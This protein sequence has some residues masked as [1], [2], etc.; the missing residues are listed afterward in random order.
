MTPTNALTAGKSHRWVGLLWAGAL[1]AIALIYAA[2]T[3]HI[4]EDFFIT[5]R[6]SRNLAEGFGLTVAE[7]MWKERP[8]VATRV[9]G[10]DSQIVSGT[11]GILIDDP[12]DLDTFSAVILG[13]LDDPER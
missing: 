11:S 12:T 7:A 3:G 8:V 5:F 4:W 9:G 13:L 6:A 10:I 1:A 2:W